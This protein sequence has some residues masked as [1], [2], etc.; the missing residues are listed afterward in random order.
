[1]ANLFLTKMEKKLIMIKKIKQIIYIIAGIYFICAPIFF[2]LLNINKIK[3]IKTYNLIIIC[4]MCFLFSVIIYK[5]I[6][7]ILFKK[8]VTNKII[9]WV[10]NYIK[11][12][13]IS[14]Y[15]ESMK[16]IDSYI[17]DNLL[18]PKY[19]GET[20]GKWSD[21]LLKFLENKESI[22]YVLIIIFF[23]I[24]PRILFLIILTMDIFV[25]NAMK[26][27][28]IFGLII[29]IKPLFS[30]I[31]FTLKEFSEYNLRNICDNNLIFFNNEGELMLT[32]DVLNDRII[33][34]P[35][36]KL[37]PIIK[38][39]SFKISCRENILNHEELLLKCHYYIDNFEFFINIRR[40]IY[41]FDII[42]QT[43]QYI[44]FNISVLFVYLSIWS[45]I[46]FVILN[47]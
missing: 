39:L 12:N 31:L 41:I 5:A 44:F 28:Y 22:I 46:L 25:Y 37:K 18:G 24:L 29:I 4:F 8:I 1:M 3:D 32:E 20:L 9:L 42:K 47:K 21:K 36:N 45:Y 26:Y 40:I 2:K 33:N 7:D 6:T 35:D 27:S 15:Y 23:D 14:F 16:I 30:Y 43:T 38:P 11:N 10:N 17:K 19:V 13:F 34:C